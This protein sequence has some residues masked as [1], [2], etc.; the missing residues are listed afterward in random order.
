[1]LVTV[2]YFGED[3]PYTWL[4]FWRDM[5][6]N[7]VIV[8]SD[9]TD[10]YYTQFAQYGGGAWLVNSYATSPPA[11]VIFAETPLELLRFLEARDAAE[12]RKG[13]IFAAFSARHA[14]F[15]D[16]RGAAFAGGAGLR[17]RRR[18][19]RRA[20]PEGGRRGEVERPRAVRGAAR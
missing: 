3:G 9:W 11:E 18:R 2:A 12:R 15:V 20:R 14:V 7:D 8:S 16:G 1:M 17:P 5:R 4:D 10:S 19:I 13:K 6:A